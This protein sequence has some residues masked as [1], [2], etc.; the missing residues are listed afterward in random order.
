MLASGILFLLCVLVLI[1]HYIDRNHTKNVKAAIS[2][3]YE[4]RLIAE[5]YILKM[6]SG[7]YQVKEVINANIPDVNKNQIIDNLLIS[8][9]E[10]HNAY[11]K[12][13]FTDA[14]EQKATELSS[15]LD[16]L[17][18]FQLSENAQKLKTANNALQ[19][20]NQLSAIQLEES[21]QIMENAESLYLSGKISSQF[22]F[23]IIIIIL[24]VLQALVFASKPL[25]QNA[26]SAH[27]N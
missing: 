15:I 2:T 13:K 17:D 20:L 1:S 9:N 24:F 23:A 8:I 5:E 14:E 19:V 4:D 26:S 11:L 22:V 12:T 25:I 21:K 6:T 7:I 16:E 3:L 18:S 27:L 10:E